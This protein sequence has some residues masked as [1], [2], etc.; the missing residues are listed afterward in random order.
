M[1]AAGVE[2]LV[3]H[4]RQ[5]A[6]AVIFLAEIVA[7]RL[8][9]DQQRH[10]VADR[11][12]ILDRERDA[13]VAGDRVDVDRR[14]GR[15]ADGGAGDDGVLERRAG[16]DVG[17]F[18][19][20]AHD[21]DRAAAGLVGDLPALAVG[22]RDGGAARQRQSER[23]GERI[24]GRGGAHGVAMADRRRRR[25][26]EVEELAV[27]DPAGGMLLARPPHHGAGAGAL[28]FPPAIEHRPAREH[29]GRD[30]DRRGRHDRRRRGLVAAG[31]EHDAVER[32]AEQHLDQAEIGEVAVERRGRPLA[33]LLDRM[34]R[35]LEGDA[36][37]VADAFAHALGELEMVAVAG[38]K[39]GAGLGDADDRLA[40]G[41]LLPGQ[42]EVEVA[43]EIERGH[44]GIVGIVEPQLRAQA[45]PRGFFS[46]CT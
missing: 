9:V 12:P 33:G 30:V 43:L 29:D 21:L 26:D 19:I 40:G 44:A 27:V 39:I 8:H 25:G 35:E 41:Q 17:G 16:E 42:P 28:A 31:R 23:L 6:G 14:I 4:R 37:G 5:S 2:Q 36:A 10:V 46:S 22:R 11:F 20:L 24:H 1:D 15:A 38:R 13:D 18:Q 3:H 32:I 45:M 34:H 7:G